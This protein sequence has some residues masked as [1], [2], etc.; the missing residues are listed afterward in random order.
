[1]QKGPISPLPPRGAALGG[2]DRQRVILLATGSV[3]AVAEVVRHLFVG[4]FAQL[5]EWSPAAAAKWFE[6]SPAT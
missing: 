2:S 3:D 5:S 6:S 4:N 1:M